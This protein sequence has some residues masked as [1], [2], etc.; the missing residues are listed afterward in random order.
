MEVV[1]PEIKPRAKTVADIM[2]DSNP[3]EPNLI[4][5]R[6]KQ[7]RLWNDKKQVIKEMI[8]KCGTKVTKSKKKRGSGAPKM[9][10]WICY[11]K[12]CSKDTGKKYMECVGDK[13]RK[14]KE[15]MPKK[16]FWVNESN[17][18]CPM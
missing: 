5:T 13:S 9:S 17:K 8:D 2:S 11:N 16:D 7:A 14:E 18:G 4:L 3:C 12:H 6:I 10:S 1:E 15:Y